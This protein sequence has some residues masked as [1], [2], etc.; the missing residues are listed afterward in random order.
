MSEAPS[1][2]VLNNLVW[3]MTGLAILGIIIALALYFR[4]VIPVHQAILHPPVNG[5]CVSCM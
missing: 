5:W 1:S 2:D 3:F 4:G